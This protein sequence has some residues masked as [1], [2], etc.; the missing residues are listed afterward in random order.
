VAL[1]VAATAVPSLAGSVDRRGFAQLDADADGALTSAELSRGA[2]L[3][4]E[5]GASG[6][7]LGRSEI[8][9]GGPSLP[10]ADRALFERVLQ[11]RFTALDADADGR[12]TFPEF[13]SR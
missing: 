13:R 8:R 5:L 6:I 7:E 9:P 2:V 1:G 3:R 12:I 11:A 10:P 4:L